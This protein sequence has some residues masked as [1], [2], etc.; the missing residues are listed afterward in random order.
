VSALIGFAL[1]GS[2]DVFP[3]TKIPLSEVCL[4]PTFA[5]SWDLRFACALTSSC[6]R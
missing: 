6:G 3:Q 2:T 5:C 1:F 4:R